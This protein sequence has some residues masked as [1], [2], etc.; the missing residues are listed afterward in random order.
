VQRDEIDKQLDDI[1][2][3]AQKIFARRLIK[4]EIARKKRMIVIT[5]VI[6]T[7]FTILG[8]SL[9]LIWMYNIKD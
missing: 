7:S 1:L 2:G 5:T 4:D 8:L 3:P 9:F 6:A